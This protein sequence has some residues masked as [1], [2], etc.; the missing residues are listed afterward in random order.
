MTACQPSL[1]SQSP[2]PST[3]LLAVV[4]LPTVVFDYRRAPRGVVLGWLGWLG[5]G[6][7]SGYVWGTFG[8]LL[9]LG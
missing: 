7:R 8:A 4:L 3:T 1:P 9:G 2:D 5:S 6:L